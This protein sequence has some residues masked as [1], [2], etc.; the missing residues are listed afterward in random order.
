MRIQFYPKNKLIKF[1]LKNLI[2][3][4]I[5]VIIAFFVLFECSFIG[6]KKVYDKNNL[7]L[8]ID[9]QENVPTDT[10][11]SIIDKYE[12]LI[13]SKEVTLK[14]KIYIVFCKSRKEYD[15]K[16]LFLSRNSLATNRNTV[17]QII[18][19]P[20]DFNKGVVIAIDSTFTNRPISSILAHEI[21]HSYELQTLGFIKFIVCKNWKAEG[22]AEYV[23]Q[24]STLDIKTATDLFVDNKEYNDS[25]NVSPKKY[26]NIFNYFKSRLRA[27]YLLRHKQ[28]PVDEFWNTKYDEQMLDDEIRKAIIDNKYQL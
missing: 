28:I 11:L 4:A 24:S 27:D 5:I 10:I 20:V 15:T 22:F 2:Y 9:K 13:Q 19:A 14:R 3:P 8:Y 1:L 6:T 7:A 25:V 21:T 18:F 12:H 23:S 16:T 26:K 17:P